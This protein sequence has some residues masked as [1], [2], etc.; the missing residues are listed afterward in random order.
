MTTTQII[1]ACVVFLLAFTV[2]SFFMTARILFNIHFKRTKKEKWSREC[3]SDDPIQ[4]AMYD[5]AISWRNANAE[6]KKDLHIVNEGFNLYGEY[7]DYGHDRAV[8]VIPGRTE[9]MYYGYYFAK[10]YAE[11]GFNVLVIDQRAHGNS[12]GVYNT[13]GFNEHRDVLAWGKLLHEEYGIKSIVLHGICIGSS[14]AMFTLTKE[15][16]PDYFLGMTAEGMYPNIYEN[17]KNHMIALK[18]PIFPFLELVERLVVKKLKV[19][20]KYGPI[21]M[22]DKLDKPILMLHSKE[23]LYSLPETAKI[24]YEKCNSEKRFVWFEHGAHSQ[25]RFADTRLYD[26][27]IDQYLND[28]II[29]KIVKTNVK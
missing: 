2:W 25:L 29:P 19:T 4:R 7:I 22:I 18:K 24:L 15:D 14:C 27:S 10:V 23:D 5:G 26:S 9:A 11:N 17:F 20:M 12:D 3:L 13:F 1:I 28:Y 16:C 21:D 8:I 6:Y